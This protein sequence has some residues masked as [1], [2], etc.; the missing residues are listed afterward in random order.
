MLIIDIDIDKKS[1]STS[2]ISDLKALTPYSPDSIQEDDFQEEISF[3]KIVKG[4]KKKK[5]DKKK[6]KKKKKNDDVEL[7]S[8]IDDSNEEK[9][10]D[11]FR[12][13][14][15]EELLDEEREEDIEGD[16]V[17]VQKKNYDK[18]KKEENPYK[19]EFAEELTLLYNLLD[20]LNKYNKKLEKKY[21]VMDNQKTRG[22][23]KYTMDMAAS[24]L[25]GKTSKL[26]VIKEIAS[27]K[28]TIAD[29]KLKHD[30]KNKENSSALSH[31]ALAVSYLQN[32]I[33]HGRSSFVTTLT[34]NDESEDVQIEGWDLDM[35]PGE[36][37]QYENYQNIIEDRL[38][39]ETNR[40]R[41]SEDGDTYIR[42]ENAGVKLYIK[43]YIDSGE[44]EMV[45]LDKNKQQIFDYPI[46]DR[47]SLGKMTFTDDGT[48]AAD[49][50]GRT[51]K[52]IEIINE[53]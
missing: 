52:V 24:I 11:E 23:S 50:Y 36:A 21:D 27:I 34:K 35:S 43:R 30:N 28:K 32:I 45:A 25:Q 15:L 6:G 16:I 18:L 5:K 44:W 8:D 51:Y 26:Q 38:S 31:D 48:F 19:K 39:N 42:Y 13:I 29:L 22:M 3:N 12:F 7:L 17:G 1:K 47:D 4:N 46:P 14:D 2:L 10:V 41:D 9:Q 33:K 49:K 53:Y 40:Y 20:E 37:S